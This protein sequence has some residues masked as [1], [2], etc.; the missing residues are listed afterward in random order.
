MYITSTTNAK[1]SLIVF[2]IVTLYYVSFLSNTTLLLMS[3]TTPLGTW[4]V[5]DTY[6]TKNILCG[7]RVSFTVFYRHM[8][9]LLHLVHLY[10][11][12][13]LSN[14][15]FALRLLM[16]MFISLRIFSWIMFLFRYLMIPYLS[17]ILCLHTLFSFC[18]LHTRHIA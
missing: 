16:N 13:V 18:Y 7:F 6:G 4:P 2:L 15:G 14:V 5:T 12:F 10:A 1:E 17:L 3:N 8:S 11:C 9:F